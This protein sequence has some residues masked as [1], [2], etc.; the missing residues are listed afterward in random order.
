M[1]IEITESKL[2]LFSFLISIFAIYVMIIIDKSETFVY[3]DLE[4]AFNPEN[5]NKV[6]NNWN[7]QNK[8]VYSFIA[9]LHFFVSKF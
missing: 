4:I 3:A 1:K 8:I 7:C 9:G 2:I 5:T 6:L